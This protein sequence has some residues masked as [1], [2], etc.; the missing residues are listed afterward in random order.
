MYSR[1]ITK[2]FL[3]IGGM[4]SFYSTCYFL[5]S[6]IPVLSFFFMAITIMII[7]QLFK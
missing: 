4:A 7:S 5:S 2:L 6:D 3:L 1:W